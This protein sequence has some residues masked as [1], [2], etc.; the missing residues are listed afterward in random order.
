MNPSRNRINLGDDSI[1]VLGKLADGNI[2]ALNVLL[3]LLK[4][5]ETI[6]PDSA[7]GAF[8]TILALDQ[9]G[10][11]GSHIWILFKYRCGQSLTKLAALLRAHQ[12][13][14]VN[15]DTVV[16]ASRDP[17]TPV[18]LDT[19]AL[20]KQVQEQLPAF[21]QPAGAAATEGSKA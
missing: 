17:N 15:G 21:G 19:D 16:L 8:G 2:G 20:L 3:N 5:N 6:D 10:I 14:L 9:L 7:V 13:G 11:Y 12:L 4:E 18:E 1:A